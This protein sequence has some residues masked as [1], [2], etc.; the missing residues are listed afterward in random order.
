ME[1]IAVKLLIAQVRGGIWKPC[2]THPDRT[3]ISVDHVGGTTGCMMMEG[4]QHGEYR[5][6]GQCEY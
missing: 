2:L 1:H 4:R 3:P 5:A 6:V